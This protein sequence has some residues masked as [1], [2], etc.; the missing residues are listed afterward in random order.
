VGRGPLRKANLQSNGISRP[1]HPAPPSIS[2]TIYYNYI[3]RPSLEA[4]EACMHGAEA[5]AS[6]AMISQFSTT[7]F[8][9]NRG[10]GDSL[11]TGLIHA[12]DDYHA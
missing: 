2:P 12:Y 11:Q 9:A 8:T 5:V 6:R 3:S 1:P 4:K 7:V 10:R